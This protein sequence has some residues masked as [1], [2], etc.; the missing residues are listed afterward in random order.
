MKGGEWIATTSTFDATARSTT[1]LSR[2]VTTIN[3]EPELPV[4]RRH[5]VLPETSPDDRYFQG[6]LLNPTTWY[7]VRPAG[8]LQ[9]TRGR[10]GGRGGGAARLA[11]I[12]TSRVRAVSR[13]NASTN[14]SSFRGA[15]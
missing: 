10:A 6:Y 15:A 1:C 14:S 4:H 8:S 3:V 5:C 13:S 12:S 9:R 7:A 2:G 11:L